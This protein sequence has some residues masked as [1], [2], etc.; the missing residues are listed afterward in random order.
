MKQF[1]LEEYLKN[2]DREVVTRDGRNVTI[3]CTNYDLRQ[4]IIAQIEGHNSSHSFTRDGKYCLDDR[5][6]P[7]DLFFAPENK[8]RWINFYYDKIRNKVYFGK[9]FKSEE[10]AKK[11]GKNQNDYVITIPI[12]WED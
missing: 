11:E 5:N 4:P 1:S 6:L 7:Y 10:K 9:V 2:P 12:E 3:H 8:E